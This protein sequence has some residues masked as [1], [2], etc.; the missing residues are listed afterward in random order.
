MAKAVEDNLTHGAF[1]NRIVALADDILGRRGRMVDAVEAMGD[2]E[3]SG[4]GV[5][6]DF[7]AAH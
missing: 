2:Y 4:H 3:Y 1:T 7:S 5:P 6:F